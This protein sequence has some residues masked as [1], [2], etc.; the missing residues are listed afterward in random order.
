MVTLQVSALEQP[1]APV[2]AVKLDP[3]AAVAVNVTTVPWLKL[4]V[5]AVLPLPQEMPDGL[6]ATDPVPF[7]AVLS[8]SANV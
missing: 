5:Q 2:Q 1:L 4:A 3:G 6:L 7:P 8:V